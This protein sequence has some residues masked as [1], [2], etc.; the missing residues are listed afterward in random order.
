LEKG[1]CTTLQIGKSRTSPHHSLSVLENLNNKGLIEEIIHEHQTKVQI[2]PP[3]KL[4][5]ILKKKQNQIKRLEENF[6]EVKETIMAKN[7]SNIFGN[8]GSLL[9]GAEGMKQM[10]WN[11][12][13][14]EGEFRGYSYCTPVETTGLKFAV[15]WAEEFNER[16]I[17]AR[18]L[19]SNHYQQSIKNHPYPSTITWPTWESRYI[20]AEN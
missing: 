4:A 9:H 15:E 16:K 12:L 10:L 1:E 5:N 11:L 2:V 7:R 17:A 3:E 18:D 6:R 8:Q 14:T 19:Y 13:K 20:S